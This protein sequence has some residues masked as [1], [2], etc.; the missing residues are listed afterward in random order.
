M[1]AAFFVWMRTAW[2]KLFNHGWTQINTD[3][4]AASQFVGVSSLRFEIGAQRRR[5]SNSNTRCNSA[6]VL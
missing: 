5:Y 4:T 6:S 3:K 1:G 2:N